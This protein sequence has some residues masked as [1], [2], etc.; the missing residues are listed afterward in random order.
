MS[1]QVII[2]IYIICVY[3][4]LNILL[5]LAVIFS[6]SGKTVRYVSK[7]RPCCP[8]LVVT[9]NPELARTCSIL[10]AMYVMKLPD[11]INGPTQ[12]YVDSAIDF[13]VRNGLCVPGKE[14]LV[15]TSTKVTQTAIHYKGNFLFCLIFFK[16]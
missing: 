7:Y 14:V 8:V 4:I 12:S 11:P 2:F 5:G 1:I 10:Y 6:E 13:G 16:K 3:K 15:L 9:S